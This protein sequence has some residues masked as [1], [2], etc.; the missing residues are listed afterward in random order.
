MGIDNFDELCL[1]HTVRT[2]METKNLQVPRLHGLRIDDD[3][4]DCLRL[5]VDDNIRIPITA[6]YELSD[7]IVPAVIWQ[8]FPGYISALSTVM[9]SATSK[10]IIQNEWYRPSH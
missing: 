8:L 6:M 9:L 4:T 3:E 5:T 2:T 10:E 1:R 7:G